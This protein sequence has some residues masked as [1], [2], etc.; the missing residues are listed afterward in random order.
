M[1]AT[2]DQEEEEAFLWGQ[3]QQ[4]QR[5]LQAQK[6]EEAQALRLSACRLSGEDMD[7]MA[8]LWRSTEFSEKAVAKLRDVG[9]EAPEVPVAAVTSQLNDME[10]GQPALGQGRQ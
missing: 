2:H 1:K 9:M 3:I 6:M 7:A 5:C 8:A 4:E 10:G